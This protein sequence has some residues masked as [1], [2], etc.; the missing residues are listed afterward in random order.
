ML[1]TTVHSSTILAETP[2]ISYHSVAAC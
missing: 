1:S 2:A